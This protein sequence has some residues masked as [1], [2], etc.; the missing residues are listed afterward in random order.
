M[1]PPHLPLLLSA[2]VLAVVPTVFSG[3]WPQWRGA[4][5]DARADGFQA[6]ERWPETLTRSWS[7]PV[8][9][10]VASPAVVENRVYVFAR[11]DGYEVLR[12]LDLASGREL[13]KD[14]Y[15]SLGADGAARSFSGP[16]SSPA[17]AQGRVIT[18]G[19]RGMISS[20]DAATGKP[21]WRKDEIQGYPQFFT[22]SSP[23]I[24][25][26]LALAQLGGRDNGAV[27]AYHLD[28]GVPQWKWN[29]PSPSYASPTLLTVEETTYV[30]AQTAEGLV[31]L[32]TSDGIL[33]W[34]SQEAP[35]GGGPGAGPG[36]GGGGGGRGGG[37]DYRA[38]SP[39]VQGDVLYLSGRNGV[40]A[41]RFVPNAEGL[42]TEDVWY[43]P[44]HSVQFSTPTLRGDHLFGLSGNNELFCLALND[45][46]TAWS[47]PFPTHP[48]PN[49]NLNPETDRRAAL[50]L[51]QPTVSS[52]AF[53][54]V[55]PN[56]PTPRGPGGPGRPGGPGGGPRRGGG[57]GGG[58]GYGNLVDAGPVIMALTP[59]G[60]L[61]V[62]K[63]TAE[64]FQPLATYKVGENQ[65]HAYPVITGNHLLIKDTNDLTLWTVE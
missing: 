22:S 63:P 17:V 10:G 42:V 9:D 31:A 29:G 58:G 48:N 20:V 44:A 62:F 39:V 40:R 7:V 64:G 25:D 4:G 49:P 5:R 37:R 47:V 61:V 30:L 27:V 53:A 41:Q 35:A 59:A 50:D 1:K 2:A 3:D 23:L 12:C 46:S 55:D 15:E 13:W 65:T 34:Q 11:Q 57:M 21:L 6:P 60:S 19:V 52:T 38:S 56:N 16:R 26:R 33:V 8:G 54:Q 43:N 51:R 32:R 45:G 18:M 14:S 28:T 24:V 36:G